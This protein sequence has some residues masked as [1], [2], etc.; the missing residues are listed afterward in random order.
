M[1]GDRELPHRLLDE[2]GL[3][4]LER[5]IISGRILDG[6]VHELM[7]GAPTATD[8]QTPG[9]E[10]WGDRERD[11]RGDCASTVA[12]IFSG[13]RLCLSHSRNAISR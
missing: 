7:P 5:R 10:R 1:A 11:R 6:L 4:Q 13:S 2:D 3:D 9:S 12:V 8:V